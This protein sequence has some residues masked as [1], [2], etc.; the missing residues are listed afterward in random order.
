[1]LML[2]SKLNEMYSNT[3]FEAKKTFMQVLLVILDSVNQ[4]INQ[5]I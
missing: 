4:K 5:I 3:Y 2:V 1:M